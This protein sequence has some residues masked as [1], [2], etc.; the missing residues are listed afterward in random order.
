MKRLII[1]C[2]GETEQEFCNTV[3]YPFFI[4]NNIIVQA[5]LLKHSHGGIV[6][7]DTLK[8]QIEITLRAEPDAYVTLLIDY[9]GLY[10]KHAFPHWDESVQYAD[11][12]ERMIFLE[13]SMRE[14]IEESIRYRFIPYIQLHEFEGLLFCDKSILERIIPK[15][16]FVGSEELEDT[17]ACYPN[18]EMIN[19]HRETSPSHR[20][21]R[22]IQGYSK[23]VYGS[24]IAESIGLSK[25]RTKC[26]R[27]NNWISTLMLISSETS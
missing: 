16:D 7:W 2:E 24:I 5:P 12:N 8:K 20:L 13:K 25:I 26:P 19:S 22:I 10:K 1:I 21:M 18:P 17:I 9:Y 6:R 4:S 11:K 23:V 15:E 14:D 3:L 27:F